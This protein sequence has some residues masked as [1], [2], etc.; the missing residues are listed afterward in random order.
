MGRSA[1]AAMLEEAPSVARRHRVERPT[2]RLYERLAGARPG[3]A[4]QRLELGEGF[5]DGV[6]IGRV[7]RQVQ[8]LAAPPL[9]ELAHPG[10]FVSGEVV[11]HY[12]SSWPK[13]RP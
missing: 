12:Y 2:H 7:G 8:K 5:F 3:S 6:E 9:D 1:V 10:A 13:R 4:Q 11:H